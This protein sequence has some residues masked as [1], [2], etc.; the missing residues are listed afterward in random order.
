VN[1]SGI[2]YLDY[3]WNPCG[4]GCSA[5]CSTCWARPI[6][7]RMG[8]ALA[9]PDCKAF[10]PHYHEERL[11]QPGGHRAAGVVGVQF[12]GDLFDPRHAS[13]AIQQVLDHAY[14]TPRHTYVF[15]TQQ[16][17][18]CRQAM[19]RWME[20]YHVSRLPTNWYVGATVRTNYHAERCWPFFLSLPGRW[21]ISAEPLGG[22]VDFSPALGT[23]GFSGIVIGAD[24]QATVQWDIEWARWAVQQTAGKVPV[25]VKQLWAW[26]CPECDG[27]LRHTPPSG[28]CGCG[29]DF[30]RRLVHEA[31]EM[32]EDMQQRE[33]PWKLT[34]K[35]STNC[36]NDT[37]GR[38]E[39]GG[40]FQ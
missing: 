19:D 26:V 40:L 17:E 6:P 13:G 21:W 36:T 12:T 9:C 27:A 1:K 23:T 29:N 24:N 18:R 32:P 15:L 3:A 10:R 33:L 28:R 30:F 16:Y 2:P 37:K 7:L 38:D 22:F 14:C 39:E 35:G 4:F 11:T 25:Y 20:R 5:G 34:T 31:A 8:K